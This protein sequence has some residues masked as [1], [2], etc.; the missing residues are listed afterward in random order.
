MN[1]M[2]AKA[3]DWT[4]LT[5]TAV[6]EL[7]LTVLLEK[8]GIGLVGEAEGVEEADG[9]ENT[10]VGLVLGGGVEGGG[11]LAGLGGGEG[12]D[13]GG[14]EGGDGKLVHDGCVDGFDE[15]DYE[16]KVAA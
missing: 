3:S 4:E 2:S 8:S 10:G 9:F 16:R 11:G 6:G 12:G 5:N 15:I 13:R 7:G 1:R 14:E